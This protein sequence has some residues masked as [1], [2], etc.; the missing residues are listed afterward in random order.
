MAVRPPASITSVRSPRCSSM[1][2]SVPAAR[3]LPS[4]IATASTNDGSPLV[5]ILA[6]WRM[7][8][9]GIW[10]S[11]PRA[12]SLLVCRGAGRDAVF[13]ELRRRGAVD[14]RVGVLHADAVR[15][16][17]GLHDVEDRV[18]G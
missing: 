13:G 6:L 12:A 4:L 15:P 7:T 11:F 3:N 14:H 2:W 18:V 9:A 1:S 17:V 8:S 10:S 5:A 16:E